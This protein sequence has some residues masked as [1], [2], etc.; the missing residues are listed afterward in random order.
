MHYD[1]ILETLAIVQDNMVS[2]TNNELFVIRSR[3]FWLKSFQSQMGII[4]R[5]SYSKLYQESDNIDDMIENDDDYIINEDNDYSGENLMDEQMLEEKEDT[6]T[7]E[8]K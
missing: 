6:T 7:G 5:R 2:P 1:T 3:Q 4:G 8:K